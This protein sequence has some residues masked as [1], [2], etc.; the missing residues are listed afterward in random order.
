MRLQ[1]KYYPI[2]QCK[3]CGDT[4]CRIVTKCDDGIEM[5]TSCRTVE[6]GWIELDEDDQKASDADK[7]NDYRRDHG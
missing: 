3:E 5:C 2:L 4:D 7:E 6:G 1:K